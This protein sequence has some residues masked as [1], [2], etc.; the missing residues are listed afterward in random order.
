MIKMFIETF[1]LQNNLYIDVNKDPS[2]QIRTS[3]KV[4]VMSNKKLKGLIR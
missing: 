3:V 4:E 1:Q 2:E